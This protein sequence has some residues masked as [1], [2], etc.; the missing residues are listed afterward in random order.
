MVQVIEA[1][2]EESIS[3]DDY[4]A[5]IKSNVDL[6]SI[7]SIVNSAKELKMLSNNRSFVS[8]FLKSELDNLDVFQ[9]NNSY[10][11]QSFLF[12]TDENF[13]I[14]MNVWPTA[15]EVK[16]PKLFAYELPHD[17]NFDFLTVGVSGSGYATEIWQYDY[18]SVQGEAGEIV[19]MNYQGRLLL[20]PGTVHFYRKSFDIHAQFPPDEFSVSLN[21]MIPNHN[22]TQ[23]FI[24]DT[25]KSRIERPI[26]NSG[27]DAS[28]MVLIDALLHF[29]DEDTE[30]LLSEISSSHPCGN[31]R[32]AASKIIR[33]KVQ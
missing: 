5:H 2:T 8:D 29:H 22:S 9:E 21:L 14:R 26:S 11:P 20:S 28:R 10:S 18:N 12:Y 31:T 23:Q 13:V 16:D 7:E 3:L 32:Q 25:E 15:S 24:F 4:V 6:S 33:N 17:H 30:N 1:A 19:K 27:S